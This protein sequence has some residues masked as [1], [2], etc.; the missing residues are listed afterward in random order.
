MIGGEG[1]TAKKK[2]EIGRGLVIDSEG[3]ISAQYF[4]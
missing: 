2:Q 3:Y 1:G 4:F